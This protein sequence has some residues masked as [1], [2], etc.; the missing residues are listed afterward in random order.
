MSLSATSFLRGLPV[1]QWSCFAWKSVIYRRPSKGPA[2]AL[3]STP[4]DAILAAPHPHFC[5]KCYSEF[6]WI[7]L[8]CALVRD[9]FHRSLPSIVGRVHIRRWDIDTASPSKHSP[10]EHAQKR[11]L[12]ASNRHITSR[13]TFD[14]VTEDFQLIIFS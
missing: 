5:P 12:R 14:Q 1:C 7:P 4:F 11:Y 8:E 6:A 3:A 13:Y 9:R 2:C 10:S